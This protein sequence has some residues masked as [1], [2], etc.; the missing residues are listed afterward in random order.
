MATTNYFTLKEYQLNNNCPE[1]YSNDGLQLTFKQKI[2]ENIFIKAITKKT[3]HEMHC[4]NC[5]TQIYPVRWDS[6]IERVVAYHERAIIPKK[7]SIK[8]KPAAYIFIIIDLLILV[9]I[10]LFMSG[11]ITI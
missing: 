7:P 3:T 6:D 1:C 11:I 5:N 10:I 2:T 9:T 4:N 8:L